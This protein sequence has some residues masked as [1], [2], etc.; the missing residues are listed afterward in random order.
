[1]ATRSATMPKDGRRPAPL[2]V[3]HV[4]H[5]R[6]R[7]RIVE[8]ASRTVVTA[9]SLLAHLD[10]AYIQRVV[11]AGDGTVTEVGPRTR[12]FRGKL[13][14]AIRARD[15]ECTHELCDAPGRECQVDHIQPYSE[16]GDT[17]QENGRLACGFHN[18][19]RNGEAETDAVFAEPDDDGETGRRMRPELLGR[20]GAL[21]ERGGAGRAPTVG[22]GVADHHADDRH[23]DAIDDGEHDEQDAGAHARG[24]EGERVTHEPE[25]DGDQQEQADDRDGAGLHRGRHDRIA[26]ASSAGVASTLR[27]PRWR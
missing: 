1:M 12:F 8:L 14:D 16:G 24:L 15:L 26:F 18:R 25:P 27:S 2:F 10:T 17:T 6:F 11:F 20:S 19:L 21:V 5:E 9:G 22:P 23:P 13:R 3:V 4:N 7:D